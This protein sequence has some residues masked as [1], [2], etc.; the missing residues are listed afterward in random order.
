MQSTSTNYKPRS[1]F[2]TGSIKTEICEQHIFT[3]WFYRR[4]RLQIA[5]GGDDELQSNTICNLVLYGQFSNFPE[6]FQEQSRHGA[7]I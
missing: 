3:L 7:R 5:G 1:N 6:A 4:Q 2:N